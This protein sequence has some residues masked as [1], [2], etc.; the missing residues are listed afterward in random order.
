MRAAGRRR[1]R[2][3]RLAQ[4]GRVLRPERPPD[5]RRSRRARSHCHVRG[6][7]GA[8]RRAGM[9]LRHADGSV[10]HPR[11]LLE[12][13]PGRRAR[14]RRRA[15]GALRRPGAR[16]AR[17]A[18][19]GR[20]PVGRGAKAAPTRPQPFAWPAS[21]GASLEVVTLNGFPYQAFHAPVVKRAVYHPSW[22]DAERS[23]Y[24]LGLAR[25][26]A[27]LLPDDVQ[28]GASRPCRSA[29]ARRLGR[30]ADA[31]ARAALESVAE[32][33]ERLE[34]ETSA[35]G[36]PSS[37]S[38]DVRSRPSPR[39]P[40]SSPACAGV[41]RA[42]PGRLPPRGPVRGCRRRLARSTTPVSVVKAQVSSAPGRGA[43]VRPWPHAARPWRRAAVPAP[44]ARARERHVAGV[45]DLPEAL[46]GG[47]PGRR[48]W[49]V[50]FHTWC[51]RATTRRK[52]SCRP[53]SPRSPAGHGR[54]PVTSRWRPI[55]GRCSRAGLPTTTSV[56]GI[57]RS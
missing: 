18:G 15:A 26:L 28:R 29:G 22:A 35:S 41:D 48:E 20:R 10:L 53:P 5:P 11:V 12:R 39:P 27:Q 52:T 14:R 33:L 55:P 7:H 21:C 25:L 6:Q 8:A 13:P 47:L 40:I 16:A 17:R 24:T 44:G 1:H 2:A 46:A 19:A 31:A 51:T 3:G 34:A 56:D 49:R 9:R 36:W 57:A 50:H 43:R 4:S 37:R 38:R 32:G 30:D 23:A 45:D 42:L 54:P